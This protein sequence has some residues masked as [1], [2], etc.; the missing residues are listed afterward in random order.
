VPNS[1]VLPRNRN[2]AKPYPPSTHTTTEPTTVRADTTM[3]FRRYVP[4]PWSNDVR[5]R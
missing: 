4:M 3:L 2:R 5:F 1:A